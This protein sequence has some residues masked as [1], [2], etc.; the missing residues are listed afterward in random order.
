MA[1]LLSR[2]PKLP[3]KGRYTM[4]ELVEIAARVN[5]C[6]E[7]A[8][9]RSSIARIGASFELNGVT[10]QSGRFAVQ[11]RVC[12]GCLRQDA[13]AAA[14]RSRAWAPYL[15]DW[16]QVAQLGSC[17]KHR[18]GLLGVCPGCSSPLDL[19]RPLAGRC[20]CGEDLLAAVCTSLPPEQVEADAYLLGRLGKWHGRAVPLADGLSFGS[21]AGLA[22]NI[23]GSLDP[24]LGFNRTWRPGVDR[25]RYGSIGL[26]ILEEGWD[27]FDRALGE[28]WSIATAVRVRRRLVGT[29]GRL[30]HW[31]N[32]EKASD[33]EPFRTRLLQH[34]ARHAAV[35]GS[36]RIFGVPLE[37][38]ERM[39]MDAARVVVGKHPGPIYSVLKALGMA[40]QATGTNR[41]D[42]ILVSA[43]ERVKKEFEEL[44]DS[45]E[46][47]AMLGSTRQQL[48]R[49]T[50]AEM[51]RQFCKGL[52]PT[53]TAYY[54]RVSVDRLASALMDGLLMVDNIPVGMIRL[55][56]ANNLLKL[57]R[58]AVFK[59]AFEGRLRLGALL[60]GTDGRRSVRNVLVKRE[61]LRT[62][63]EGTGQ[64]RYSY[65][66]AG[67]VLGISRLTVGKLVTLVAP[68]RKPGR[69]L[70]EEIRAMRERFVTRSEIVAAWPHRL[71]GVGVTKALANR[72]VHPVFDNLLINRV[73][74][75]ADIVAALGSMP[76]KPFR[77]P[78]GTAEQRS[79]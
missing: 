22:L 59:A 48:R 72:G 23:G 67:S 15:R 32:F 54:R 50:A 70:H 9:A 1:E 51:I 29:Y 60:V 2:T 46:A 47:E 7:A 71:R 16:W 68:S 36:T 52:G 35:S 75:R 24:N 53:S 30:Q 66:E 21:A 4:G 19:R 17:P 57:E 6:E 58:D 69:L 49:F 20:R 13:A 37:R 12:V 42:L 33:L 74:Y 27:A 31:L 38:A 39:T 56:T 61:D 28:I 11:G 8:L 79:C 76:A 55:E 64:R 63:V 41:S 18:L 43:V 44:V 78:L 62:L 65:A 45:A 40:D 34:A 25:S 26:Q 14:A 77:D 73:F 10:V 5:G 3:R